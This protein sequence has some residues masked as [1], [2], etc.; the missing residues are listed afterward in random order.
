MRRAGWIAAFA[1]VTGACSAAAQQPDTAQ[2][3]G[4]RGLW[5]RHAGD[6]VAVSW[7]TEPAQAGILEVHDGDDLVVR[8]ATAP[9]GVHTALF[10][11]PRAAD[12]LLRYG[13]VGGPHH[14]TRVSMRAPKRD[15]VTVRGVDSLYVLGDTHGD[16]DALVAG[17]QAAGLIDEALH[18][19]GGRS[20]VVFAGD[21]VDRG[22]DVTRLLWLV[23]RLEREAAEAGGRIHVLLGNHEIMVMLGD[24]R[25]VHPREQRLAEL[26]GV[27]YD[28]L[29]DVRTSVLGRWLASKP[30]VLRVD[31]VLIAHGGVTPEHAE[32]GLREYDD[33]LRSYMAEELFYR[34][35]DTTAVIAMDSAAYERRI[36]F[37]WGERSAF[38]H[39]GYVQ[40]DSLATD[41]EEVLRRT[42]SDVLVVGHTAIPGID[43]R[44]GGRLIAAH[45]PA[46][47][48]SLL[49]LVRTPRGYE[50]WR[51][52]EEGRERLPSG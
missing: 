39:R 35:S 38:W 36:D 11:R 31:G 3:V 42:D 21:L 34:W 1:L 9:A 2:L 12:V 44:Y 10:R 22:P 40:S 47:G 16:Y 4:E 32:L 25:Y 5:V 8:R 51:I 24:L 20:H 6:S 18:W 49:L 28:R 17:L 50:R 19:S 48:A 29:F 46:F 30:A 7:I 15:P 33:S 23:Y 52:S 27:R 41:L 14:E 13:G 26:H 37:F 45:T 43:A